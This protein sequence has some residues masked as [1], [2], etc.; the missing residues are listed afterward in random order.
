MGLSLRFAPGVAG[1]FLLAVFCPQVRSWHELRAVLRSTLLV[2]AVTIPAVIL[3]GVV[4]GY[5]RWDPK[6]PW[7]TA[8]FVAKTLLLTAVV[9]E[10]F[11]RGVLQEGLSRWSW[12]AAHPGRRWVPVVVLSL[13]FGLAHARAG[14]LF[15]A[16]ATLAGLGYSM[17]YALTRRIEAPIVV[18]AGLHTVHFRLC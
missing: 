11:F 10:A 4:S 5:V 15:A 18:H 16:L 6:L 1:L 7:F 9:E 8:A 14:I 3:V 13:L 17:A 12:I 2:A